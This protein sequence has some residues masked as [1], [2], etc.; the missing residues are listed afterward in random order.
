MVSSTEEMNFKFLF[1]YYKLKFQKPD[2]ASE[3]TKRT[4]PSYGLSPT[5][6]S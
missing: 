6:T 4:Y 2:V 1:N 5:N 3:A